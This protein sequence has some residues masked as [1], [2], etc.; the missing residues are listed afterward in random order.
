MRDTMSS[1]HAR[2]E[3]PSNVWE[4]EYVHGLER[5][6]GR[7]GLHVLRVYGDITS[8]ELRGAIERWLTEQQL[9]GQIVWHHP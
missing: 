2:I 8:P 7:Y 9:D 6:S 5:M 4:I 1:S 3:G